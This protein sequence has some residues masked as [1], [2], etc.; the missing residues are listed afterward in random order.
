MRLPVFA[1]IASCLLTS[2]APVPP[3]E[4]PVSA[5]IWNP[6]TGRY[7]WPSGE[8]TLP[9]HLRYRFSEDRHTRIENFVSRDWRISIGAGH[10]LSTTEGCPYAS[11][12]GDDGVKLERVVNGSRVFVYRGDWTRF[13]EH[14]QYRPVY[15]MDGPRGLGW[16]L[17]PDSGCAMIM[18]ASTRPADIAI[19]DSIVK[20]FRPR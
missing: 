18:V 2:C 13:H 20:T 5:D 8:V 17:F 7:R 14:A 4:M 10:E 3:K 6:R 19:I 15:S 12:Q 16:V 9:V 1:V 11:A